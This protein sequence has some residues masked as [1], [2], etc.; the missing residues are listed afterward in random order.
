MFHL[1]KL[2]IYIY[3]LCSYTVISIRYLFPVE[4]LIIRSM[5]Q[6]LSSVCSVVFFVYL[7]VL[8]IVDNLFCSG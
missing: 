3:N 6:Y 4:I 8:F 7:L 2:K 1:T 5:H